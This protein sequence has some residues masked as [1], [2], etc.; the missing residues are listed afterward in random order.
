MNPKWCMKKEIAKKTVCEPILL[1]LAR[2]AAKS[3]FTQNKARNF[4]KTSFQCK[5]CAPQIEDI[6]R[7][8]L[9]TIIVIQK[10]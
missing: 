8:L 4:N 3:I 9:I 1:V 6:H 10:K 5:L 7:T 2:L